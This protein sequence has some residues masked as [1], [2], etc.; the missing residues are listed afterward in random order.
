MVRGEGRRYNDIP[1]AVTHKVKDI[2]AACDEEKFHDGIVQGYVAE[3]EI[4][5]AGDED[6]H[7]QRLRFE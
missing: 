3:E 4:E 5:V 6:K 2:A 1:V 7:I